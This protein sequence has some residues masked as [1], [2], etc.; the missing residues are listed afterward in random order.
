LRITSDYEDEDPIAE[1][2][3]LLLPS[4]KWEAFRKEDEGLYFGRVKSSLTY[5]DWEWGYF[6]QDQL[7][8]AKAYRVDSDLS[9]DEP[10]FP[11]GGLLA[12]VYETELEALLEEGES[13]YNEEE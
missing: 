10:V 12:E 11:D 5:D 4:W 9:G 7:E 2:E 8:E 6:S 13:R 3:A 1:W